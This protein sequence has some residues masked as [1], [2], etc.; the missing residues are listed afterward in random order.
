MTPRLN[1]YTEAPELLKQFLHVSQQIYGSGL[2]KSLLNLVKIRASQINGCANCLNMHTAEA[3]WIGETDQ[4]LHLIA[5]WH[6]APVFSDRER[7]A[8]RWTD[9]V[10]LLPQS[11]DDEGA[12]AE[13]DAHFTKAEQAKLTMMITNINAWNRLAVGFKLFD[14]SLGW[15]RE[16][17]VREAV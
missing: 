13:L 2:E 6:E 14:S 4:R 5:A 7:A 10:T 12:Y 15:D 16:Q 9:H 3:H 11:K 1:P 17:R 8:L